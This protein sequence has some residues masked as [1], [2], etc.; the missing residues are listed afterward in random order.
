[1]YKPQIFL[2]GIDRGII[3]INKERITKENQKI[4]PKSK[5]DTEKLSLMNIWKVFII[6]L[7]REKQ[8]RTTIRKSFVYGTCNNKKAGK[9]QMLAD[10]EYHCW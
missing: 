3:Q 2:S 7:C 4:F 8:V 6:L 10:Y 5:H 9:C 1:M